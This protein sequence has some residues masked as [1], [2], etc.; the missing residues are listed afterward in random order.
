VIPPEED[1]DNGW[2]PDEEY[3]VAQA[4]AMG[5]IFLLLAYLIGFLQ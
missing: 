2:L 4:L 1:E 5:S 3:S